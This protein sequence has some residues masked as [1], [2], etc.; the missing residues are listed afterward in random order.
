MNLINERGLGLMARA[1]EHVMKKHVTL[2]YGQEHNK[3]QSTGEVKQHYLNNYLKLH[4]VWM[5]V[6]TDGP[7]FLFSWFYSSLFPGT[8]VKIIYSSVQAIICRLYVNAL[9]LLNFVKHCYGIY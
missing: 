8:K 7:F 3:L 4:Q 2:A 5:H 6:S 1:D 9:C